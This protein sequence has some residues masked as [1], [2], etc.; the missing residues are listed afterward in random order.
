V[1]QV[2]RRKLAV[3]SLALLGVGL[4]AAYGYHRVDLTTAL[5]L[6]QRPQ[7]QQLHFT[8]REVPRGRE[9]Y[10]TR[11]IYT[12]YRRFGGYGESWS[13]DYPK[14]DRQFVIGLRRLTNIEAYELENPVR[15]DDPELRRYP[16]LYA[17]EVGYMSLTESEVE[18]LRDYLLAGG[19]LVID[20]F[21]GT[22][23]WENF[24]REMHRVLPGHPIVDVPMDHP[25]MSAFYEIGEILQ[26][27]N[28]RQGRLGGRTWENDGYAPALKGIF[29]EYGRLMVAINWNTDLG[30]AWEWA[31]DPYYPLRFSNFAYQ[32]GINLIIYGM[33]H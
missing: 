19:F 22:A 33:S 23:E 26:V 21:W 3:V 25:L 2:V 17:L 8:P 20:D 24:E 12:G 4:P 30:D 16:L 10:F 29:D 28:V 15:L 6:T 13:I 14:A 32:M 5:A 9:F 18:G 31:D 1:S 27:P 7:R 11:A